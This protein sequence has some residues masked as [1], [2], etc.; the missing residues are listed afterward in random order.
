GNLG[1]GLA[2]QVQA[3]G[4]VD[5]RQLL[6]VQPGNAPQPLEAFACGLLRAHHADIESLGV[7]RLHHGQVVDARVVGQGDHGGVAVAT[8]L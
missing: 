2:A 8:S 1:G 4:C 3:D 5:A 6:I 7:N